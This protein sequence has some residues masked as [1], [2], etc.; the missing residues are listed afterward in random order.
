MIVLYYFLFFLAAFV[1]FYIPGRFFIRLLKIKLPL[2]EGLTVNVLFGISLFTLITYLLSWIKLSYVYLFVIIGLTLHYLYRTRIKKTDLVALFKKNEWIE[3]C[4]IFFGSI[5]FLLIMFFSGLETDKGIQFAWINATDGVRHLAY[6][7]SQIHTFPPQHPVLAGIPLRGFHYFYDF[8]LAKFISF[9]PFNVGDVYFRFFPFLISLIYGAGFYIFASYLTDSKLSKRLT[10]FFAYFSQ[11]STFIFLFFNPKFD[12]TTN[13]LVQPIGLIVNPF[14]VLSIPLLLLGIVYIPKIRENMAYGVLVILFLGIL[15]QIKVYAGIIG[16][17]V[18]VIYSFYVFIKKRK[19]IFS[20][21]FVLI[22]TAI[23]TA[24]TYL[25]NNLGS[26]GLTFAPFLFYRHF[27]ETHL[28][29][30]LHWEIKREIFAQHNNYPRIILLYIEA[31]I[32]FFTLNLGSRLVLL[33][34]VQK[35]LKKRFWTNDYNLLVLLMIF[36]PLV[37]GSFFIQSVSPFDTVQ[38]FWIMLSILSIP[39]AVILGDVLQNKGRILQLSLFIFLILVSLPGLLDIEK[40]YTVTFASVIVPKE[41]AET[42]KAVASLVPENSFIVYIPSK[43]RLSGD[44]SAKGAPIIS[45]VTGRSLYFET[46]GLPAKN[47]KLYLDREKQLISLDRALAD[48][49]LEEV[50]KQLKRIGSVYLMTENNYK[51]FFDTEV[52]LITP[53]IKFYKIKT[54]GS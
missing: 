5:S 13:A 54:E 32:I 47:E 7:E 16:I 1:T 19:I 53:S 42:L 15:S 44:V 28:F 17:I 21:I 39:C 50:K 6:I 24:V 33:L 4:I 36:I 31:L 51:C 26:G 38:F 22:S 43:L 10:L 35:I 9:F 37:F 34:G 45:A 25:P 11:S 29:D 27:M 49:H 2:I 12:I 23:I 46:G 20:Y 3:I 18:L 40:K 41:K 8:L 14:T 52:R 30:S 48:C